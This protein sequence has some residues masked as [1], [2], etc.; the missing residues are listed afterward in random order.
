M[1]S[2]KTKI[3]LCINQHFV[4]ARNWHQLWLIQ[5]EKEIIISDCG[6]AGL[7]GGQKNQAQKGQGSLCSRVNA[8]E[9]ESFSSWGAELLVWGYFQPFCHPAQD[10]HSWEKL[11]D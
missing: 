8:G 1:R 2:R 9:L 6:D 5:A 4:A 10:P 7:K 3:H 11:S